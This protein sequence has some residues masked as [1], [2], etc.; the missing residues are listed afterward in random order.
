[1]LP[2]VDSG[3]WDAWLDMVRGLY[4]MP[5]EDDDRWRGLTDRRPPDQALRQ[6]YVLAGR[7]GGKTA[8][9]AALAVYET[10]LRDWSALAAPGERIVGAVVAADRRQAGQAMRYMTGGLEASPVLRGMV[11]R[12]TTES[13]ELAGG[14]ELAVMTASHRSIRGRSFAVLIADELAHWQAEGMSPDVEI[15]RAAEPALSLTN[16]LLLGISTPHRRDGVL[17]SR[18]RRNWGR[19]DAQALVIQAPSTTMNPRLPHSLVDDALAEDEPAA[20][21]EYLAQFRDDLASF[22]DRTLV[23]SL[24]P[25]DVTERPPE[26]RHRYRAFVDVSGGRGDA[27]TWAIAHN[28]GQ[29][30]VLDLVREVRPPFNPTEVVSQCVEDVRRYRLREV[31]GDRYAGEWVTEAFRDAGVK[32]QASE[33]NRSELYL[34]LLPAM[35][36]GQIEL[37]EHDRLVAQLAALERRTRSGG[38]DIVDHPRHGADDVANAVAGALVAA[39]RTSGIHKL[40]TW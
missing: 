7:R 26:Q 37:L 8:I 11:E 32:Y 18:Y 22:V 12:V 38:R 16:G 5:V 20:R 29:T 2:G 24:V 17:Y 33:K 40:N 25:P 19:D 10:A 14:V 30:S 34:D 36:A 4:G 13:V 39:P 28:E 6:A 31:T 1:M 9:S 35:T 23:E 21:S 15:L 3:S 27:F